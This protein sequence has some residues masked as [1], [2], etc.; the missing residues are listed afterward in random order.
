MLPFN[1]AIL[2]AD[3]LQPSNPGL[4]NVVN[5]ARLARDVYESVALIVARNRDVEAF[6]RTA[7]LLKPF[8]QDYLELVGDSE[9]RLPIIS[10]YLLSLLAL[11]DLAQFHTE[12]E[13]LSEKDKFAP[14]VAAVCELDRLM[15]EGA[16]LQ[17]MKTRDSL[18]LGDCNACFFEVLEKTIREK[19]ADC[20]EK[21][22][23][24]YPVA[25]LPQLLFLSNSAAAADFIKAREW[26][27]SSNGAYV[28][29]GND[30]PF[31]SKVDA[32]KV[33]DNILASS[34]QIERI[35]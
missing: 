16:Y 35:V 33:I 2:P 13:L 29:F 26:K 7:N 10:L 24:S 25:K 28:E 27:V 22:Y 23:K 5:N 12:L 9:L 30:E 8:Y 3:Q 11:S 4:A 32:H 17:A 18:P 31:Q 20:A 14:A 19:I 6:Q 1:V 21:S 15:M 34:T